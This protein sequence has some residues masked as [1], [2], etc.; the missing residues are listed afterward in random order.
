MLPEIMFYQLPGHP[1]AQS[2]WCIKLTIT[3]SVVK[4]DYSFIHRGLFSQKGNKHLVVILLLLIII[5]NERFPS[6]EEGGWVLRGRQEEALVARP[7]LLHLS[8]QVLLGWWFM[9]LPCRQ[10]LWKATEVSELQEGQGGGFLTCWVIG[11]CMSI[12]GWQQDL[13]K[14]CE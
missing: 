3:M 10:W 11:A 4:N 9:R 12:G 13:P 14:A 6:W 8:S 1:L 7:R 5:T 2:S